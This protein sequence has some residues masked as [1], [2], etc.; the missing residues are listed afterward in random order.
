MLH[1]WKN[2]PKKPKTSEKQELPFA[3][4]SS[5]AFLRRQPE[6]ETRDKFG[7]FCEL[8]RIFFLNSAQYIV[9]KRWTIRLMSEASWKGP[10]EAM[11]THLEQSTAAIEMPFF[12]SPIG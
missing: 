3:G 10:G 2:L 9:G 8:E 6:K 1:C 5:A 12:G 4:Q 11:K 7:S